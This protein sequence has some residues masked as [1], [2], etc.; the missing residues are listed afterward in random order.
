MTSA[1][2]QTGDR[3]AGGGARALPAARSGFPCGAAGAR[4]SSSPLPFVIA[5]L[6]GFYSANGLREIQRRDAS[7][8]SEVKDLSVTG[9]SMAV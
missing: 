9:C 6:S 2:R 4:G 7:T 5:S 8:G 1:F 3:G